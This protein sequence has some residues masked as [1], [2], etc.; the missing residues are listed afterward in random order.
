MV[1]VWCVVYDVSDV[2]IMCGVCACVVWFAVFE[3]RVGGGGRVGGLTPHTYTG[4]CH[5]CFPGGPRVGP[6][7]TANIQMPSVNCFKLLSIT[8]VS[9]RDP[10]SFTMFR[11]LVIRDVLMLWCVVCDVMYDVFDAV[12]CGV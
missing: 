10:Q 1:S 6:L 4:P 9:D 2:C 5:L 11:T 12:M 8:E 7:K 3:M